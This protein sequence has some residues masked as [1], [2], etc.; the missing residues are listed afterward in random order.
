MCRDCFP[1]SLCTLSLMIP[2]VIDITLRVCI[3]YTTC[4]AN[5]RDGARTCG[6]DVVTH[7]RWGEYKSKSF[8]KVCRFVQ[9]RRWQASEVWQCFSCSLLRSSLH[10]AYQQE[11]IMITVSQCCVKCMWSETCSYCVYLHHYCAVANTLPRS[12]STP[13][14]RSFHLAFLIGDRLTFHFIGL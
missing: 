7:C 11:T 2:C 3:I 6:C 10:M 1:L 4:T 14:P 9:K 8:A 5:D 13:L 12:F